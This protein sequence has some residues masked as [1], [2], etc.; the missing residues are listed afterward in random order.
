MAQIFNKRAALEAR[1][2]PAGPVAPEEPTEFEDEADADAGFS[3]VAP[4]SLNAASAHAATPRV[5]AEGEG[6]VLAPGTVVEGTLRAAEPV[7]VGGTL[8]GVLEAEG[9]VVVEAGGRLVA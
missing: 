8:Q 5:W 3:P 4:T 7:Q 2:G 9:P 6:T 1:L